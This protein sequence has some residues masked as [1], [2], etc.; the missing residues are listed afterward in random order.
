MLSRAKVCFKDGY[1]LDFEPANGGT[2]FPQN[3]LMRL[4]NFAKQRSGVLFVHVEDRPQPSIPRIMPTQDKLHKNLSS[5]QLK[6]A[7]NSRRTTN[8]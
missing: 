1:E 2:T 3:E 5:S 4:N 7:H 8:S 6:R